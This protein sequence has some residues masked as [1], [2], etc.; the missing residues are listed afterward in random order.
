[1]TV[2]MQY[3]LIITAAREK[4]LQLTSRWAKSY[5]F[6]NSQTLFRGKSVQTDPALQI[7]K[8]KFSKQF[9]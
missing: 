6:T 7:E 1:M 9:H 3:L 5:I 4:V 8:Y 2:P